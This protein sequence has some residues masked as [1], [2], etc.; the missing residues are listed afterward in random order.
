VLAIAERH[1]SDRDL[2]HVVDGLAGHGEG[3]VP[4]LAV[5]AQLIGPDRYRGSISDF[6]TCNRGRRRSYGVGNAE[7]EG[8]KWTESWECVKEQLSNDG[9][10]Q[11]N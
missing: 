8:R 10:V 1:A 6:S 5:R 4:D 3:V 9:P 7:N 2:V 11:A